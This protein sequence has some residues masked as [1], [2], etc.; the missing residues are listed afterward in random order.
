MLRPQ[1]IPEVKIKAEDDELNVSHL[2]YGAFDS[3]RRK[4]QRFE[5]PVS[6][7][8]YSGHDFGGANPAALFV[9][10]AKLPL[11]PG[12]PPDMRYGDVV[13]FNEYLPGRGMSTS[14][15]VDAFRGLVNKRTDCKSAGGNHNEDGSRGDYPRA[16]WPILEPPIGAG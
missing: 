14:L 6:W 5:V 16:G 13:C 11:P 7:P 2:V 8:I 9:A 1:G 15:N 12:A 10:R 4:C 3:T